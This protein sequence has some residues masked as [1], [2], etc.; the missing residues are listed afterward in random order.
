MGRFGCMMGRFGQCNGSFWTIFLDIKIFGAVLVGAVLAMGH[1]GIDL[2]DI[3]A[4]CCYVI[5]LQVTKL[6]LYGCPLASLV[7]IP[8]IQ[9]ESASLI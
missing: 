7:H 9:P 6:C 8:A 5:L 2:F 3:I 1:F 4:Y